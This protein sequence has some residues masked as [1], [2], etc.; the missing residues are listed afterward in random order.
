MITSYFTA[1][2]GNIK[3]TI[4]YNSMGN[5]RDKLYFVDNNTEGLAVVYNRF[6]KTQKDDNVV[7]L[8]D[9][10]EF[11]ES[12]DSIEYKLREAHRQFDIVGLA[13]ATQQNIQEPALWHLMGGGF[14]GGNLRGA[15]AHKLTGTDKIHMTGF[16]PT[17]D[18]CLV[19][20]GLFM[21]V[22]VAKAKSV[23]WQFNENYDFHHYDL[24]SCLDAHK[25]KLK[26]G[27]WPIFVSHASPGLNNLNDPTFVRN[28]QKFLQEYAN[29]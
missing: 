6:L 27:V 14:H 25:K 13:G 10:I 3:N 15:V 22:N 5:V 18:R 19:V 16:G 21:S 28:Q 24:A 20:D 26:I 1:T 23:A 11:T 29:Y 17:P 7:F 12:Q 4:L 2:R 8:H 9:D